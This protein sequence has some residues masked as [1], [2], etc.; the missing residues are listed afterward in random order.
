MHGGRREQRRDRR[1]ARRR[2]RG[3]R[4]SAIVAAVHTACAACRHSSSSARSRPAARPRARDRASQRLRAR[5][6]SRRRCAELLELAV[7]AGRA[8]RIVTRRQSLGPLA[9]QVADGA[10][11]RRAGSS[12]APRACGSIGGFVTCANCCLKYAGQQLRR[13]PRAPRAACRRPSSR[14]ARRRRAP[15]APSSSGAPRRVAEA[16]CSRA[17]SSGGQRRDRLRAQV[18]EVQ[19]V[20]VEP[21]R[22]RAGGGPARA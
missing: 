16:C 8:V 14:P 4:G 20:L 22:G 1:A 6:P 3:R 13:A 12:P 2:R 10:D 5:S 9:E 7:R 18:V 15:S 21:A 17:S 11:A 19:L